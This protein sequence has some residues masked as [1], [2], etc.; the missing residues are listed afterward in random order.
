MELNINPNA[1]TLSLEEVK[2]YFKNRRPG[3][4]TI[5]YYSEPIKGMKKITKAQYQI[6]I[7][8]KHRKNYVG[9]LT[10]RK[11]EKGK[12]HYIIPYSLFYHDGSHHYNIVVYPFNS[13]NKA[14]SKYYYNG[15]EIPQEQALSMYSQQ[16]APKNM[17]R[18]GANHIYEMV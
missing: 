2:N 16:P 11:R 6:K 10:N 3:F 12:I 4:A 18:I 17:K 1:Q 5:T 8:P 9:S 13:K 14:V 7:N 15:V